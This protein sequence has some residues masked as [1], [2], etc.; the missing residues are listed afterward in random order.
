MYE[1]GFSSSSD[2]VD[3]VTGR[4]TRTLTPYAVTGVAVSDGW[5]RTGETPDSYLQEKLPA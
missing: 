1:D 2:D 3:L 4:T 5:N